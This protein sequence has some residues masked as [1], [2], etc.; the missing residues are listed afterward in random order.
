M[1]N[2]KFI[3]VILYSVVRYLTFF[4]ILAFV[5]NRFKLI[6]IDNSENGKEIFSNTLYYFLSFA[7]ILVLFTFIFSIPLYFLIKKVKGVFFIM[8]YFILLSIEYISYT[9]LASPSDLNN[10]IY[11]TIIGVL[12]LFLFFYKYLKISFTS[13]KSL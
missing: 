5:G 1:E 2:I 3:N 9:Y 4:I 10:G 11:N 12:F 7:D 13:N 6:V 8:L